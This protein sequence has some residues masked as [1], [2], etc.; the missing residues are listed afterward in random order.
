MSDVEITI[1]IKGIGKSKE[2]WECDGCHQMTTAEFI[3]DEGG[4]YCFCSLG[5]LRRWNDA[6]DY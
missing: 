5:C 2:E 6:H 3:E 1:T 4:Q